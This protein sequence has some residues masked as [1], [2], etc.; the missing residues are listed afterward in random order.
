MLSQD[1]CRR[2]E[3]RMDETMAVDP[4]CTTEAADPTK[5]RPATEASV[6]RK[7][8]KSEV[9][10][11]GLTALFLYTALLLRLP[12][13]SPLMNALLSVIALGSF[14]FYLRWRLDIRVPTPFIC[15]LVF[16][17]V[18]D[19]IGNHFGLFSRRVLLIPYDT[20]THFVSSAL[21]LIPVMWL[22]LTLIERYGFKLPLGFIAFFSLTTTFSLGAYYEITEL[23]DERFF[24]GH[25]IWTPRD[26]VQD[27]AADL[28]GIIVATLLY[29]LI[30]RNA[31]SKKTRLA[32]K[33]NDEL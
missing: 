25:R 6:L 12:Y 26:T 23:M 5:A 2:R 27:L 31:G 22:L 15:F 30:I 4:V 19:M 3:K 10:L 13:R 24:G 32:S 9:L 14:Y 18:I 28:C 29:T 21:S 33:A 11:A 7:P 20:I 16:A 8:G 1:D 17:L